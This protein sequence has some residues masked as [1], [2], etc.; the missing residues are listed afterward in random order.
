MLILKLLFPVFFSIS[1]LDAIAIDRQNSSISIRAVNLQKSIFNKVISC[2]DCC[3][4]PN[5]KVCNMFYNFCHTETFK[6][7]KFVITKNKFNDKSV[8]RELKTYK[9]DIKNIVL[10][11][12]KGN[13]YFFKNDYDNFKKETKKNID[14]LRNDPKLLDQKK[15]F[16]NLT[17]ELYPRFEKAELVYKIKNLIKNKYVTFYNILEAYSNIVNTFEYV[18]I[19]TIYNKNNKD[20]CMNKL[21]TTENTLIRYSDT[22]IKKRLKTT[23]IF[24]SEVKNI[25]TDNNFIPK[26]DKKLNPKESTKNE[27]FSLVIIIPTVTITLV[28]AIISAVFIYKK[29][30]KSNLIVDTESKQQD[31]N[32]IDDHIYDYPTIF[33]GELGLFIQDNRQNNINQN[34]PSIAKSDEHIYI[35][36]IND[37]ESEH[38]INDSTANKQPNDMMPIQEHYYHILE[39]GYNSCEQIAD[40]N[41]L[42]NQSS[43]CEQMADNHNKRNSRKIII[44][45]FN[46]IDNY[47]LN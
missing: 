27:T 20:L 18:N 6:D 26:I 37:Y 24:F 9:G 10:I 47:Y 21:K 14:R 36:C 19:V 22:V 29:S 44:P 3:F 5:K 35:P 4:L 25:S 40:N 8:I 7:G 33:D 17:S 41:S 13:I 12:I 30:K 43:S 46:Y 45:T 11:E 34:I 16:N 23:E 38:T 15:L 1:P 31:D 42:D 28:I 39:D 32:H 2:E